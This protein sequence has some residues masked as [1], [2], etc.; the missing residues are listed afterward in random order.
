MVRGKILI[1]L[2]C[3][4]R[5]DI[6][7]FA[8]SVHCG[9]EME[10]PVDLT[11]TQLSSRRRSILTK[12]QAMEIFRAK[13]SNDTEDPDKQIRAKSLG[14]KFGVSEKAVRDVWKG[15]TW[16]RETARIDPSMFLVTVKTRLPGRPKGSK[17][18]QQRKK[19][20]GSPK[21]TSKIRLS[22][23]LVAAK[24]K[25]VSAAE[26]L[27]LQENQSGNIVGKIPT[28]GRPCST[29]VNGAGLNFLVDVHPQ[30]GATCAPLKVPHS[31]QSDLRAGIFP[32]DFDCFDM[33]CNHN[34]VFPIS[35]NEDDPFHDDWIRCQNYLHSISDQDEFIF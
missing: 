23:K 24:E 17:D 25:P 9:I 11:S 4:F 35:A 18:K 12:D 10:D 16:F 3:C 5:Y 19:S 8:R 31:V 6:I 27:N 33:N 22:V 14:E 30:V 26:V 13:L 1:T 15:R 32:T 29:S 21:V 28:D 2:K 20:R 34:D 7:K